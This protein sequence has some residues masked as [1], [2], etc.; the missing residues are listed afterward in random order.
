MK[1]LA[2]NLES[3]KSLAT[4]G[5]KVIYSDAY[6]FMSYIVTDIF[7]GGMELEALTDDCSVAK[8]EKEDIFFDSLQLGWQLCKM[9]VDIWD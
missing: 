8:G 1:N 6:N 2:S 4:I 9:I 3:N 7:E 5:D